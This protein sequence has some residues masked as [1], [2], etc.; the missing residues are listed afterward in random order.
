MPEMIYIEDTVA[1]QTTAYYL[2]PQLGL[3]SV[4]AYNSED[5]GPHNLLSQF[6]SKK[7]VI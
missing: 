2:E 1:Q 3:A 4:Y 7:M 5:F 6:M